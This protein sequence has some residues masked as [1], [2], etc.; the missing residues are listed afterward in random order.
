MNSK[1]YKVKGKTKKKYF[2]DNKLFVLV[3]IANKISNLQF[4]VP[5]SICDRHRLSAM[6][7]KN[8]RFSYGFGSLRRN[9]DDCR[10]A[11]AKV[12]DETQQA[13]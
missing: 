12:A 7:K 4:K 11:T 1:F 9:S 10:H 6:S 3:L 8:Q 13:I 2:V 5:G